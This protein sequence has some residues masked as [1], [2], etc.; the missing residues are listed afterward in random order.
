MTTKTELVAGRS[1]QAASNVELTRLS[2]HK[3][4]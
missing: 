3:V 4:T 1:L 2:S